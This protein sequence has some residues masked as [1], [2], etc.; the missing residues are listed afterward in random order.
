MP[1]VAAGLVMYRRRNG[2]L[3]FFLGHPGGPVM[4]NK[5]E[6]F[7]TIPKGE[8]DGTEP[9]LEVAQREFQEETGI[10]AK[11]PFVELGSIQQRGGKI[12]HAWGFEG[13]HPGPIESNL[14][15]M[16]WPPRSG[17]HQ[18]FPELDRA[19]FFPLKQ[20]CVKIKE[21]QIPLLERLAAALG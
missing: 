20:A 21:A 12:V 1:R 15:A 10:K 17:N 9:L 3:E 19:E 18:V 7:W 6:G 4:R 11:P 5:D 14:V 13:D 2:V 8:P 16:E